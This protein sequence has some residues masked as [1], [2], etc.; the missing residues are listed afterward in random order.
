MSRRWALA[1]TIL[2]TASIATSGQTTAPAARSSDVILSEIES[3]HQQFKSA[4]KD[5]SDISDPDRRKAVAPK[6]IPALKTMIADF[7]ELATIQPK[8]RRHADQLE[9]QFDAFLSVLGD[10]P[11]I[12]HLQTLA[13]S[14][15]LY[16]SLRGQSSQLLA[17]WVQSRTDQ[18]AQEKLTD[19]LETLDRAHPENEDLTF[20][21]VTVS[22]STTFKPL[23][24][25]LIGLAAAMKNPPPTRFVPPRSR[26]ERNPICVKKAPA[27]HPEP[28]RITAF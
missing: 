8:T 27:L 16:D 6:A 1:P 24:A 11:T 13:N 9:L 26:E 10:Q 23:E 14:K 25:R 7:Q 4:V 3:A 17:S 19:Q 5:P 21:T 22:Q 28:L 2:L 15:D 20:V 18:P 12:D